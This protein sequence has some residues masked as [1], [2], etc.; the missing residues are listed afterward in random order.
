MF[1]KKDL[2]V[3]QYSKSVPI[4]WVSQ[5]G[6][7]KFGTDTS[8][9]DENTA[10]TEDPVQSKALVFQSFNC[11]V[12]SVILCAPETSVDS[13]SEKKLKDFCLDKMKQ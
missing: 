5:A 8:K 3:R 11:K 7:L 10:K 12:F 2:I 1:T 4:R 6:I 9:F 13:F